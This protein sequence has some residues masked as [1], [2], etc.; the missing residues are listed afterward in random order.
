MQLLKSQGITELL[1]TQNMEEAMRLC[2]RVAI[3]HQGRL[4]TVDR[5]ADLVHK[6]A[7]S[8][9]WELRLNS[10]DKNAIIAKL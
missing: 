9:I 8:E 2:D 3:M 7:G 4:L 1:C 10:E 6:Y 5:P